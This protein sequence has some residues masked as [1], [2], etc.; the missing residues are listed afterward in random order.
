MICKFRHILFG[1]PMDLPTANAKTQSTPTRKY[2]EIHKTR[3]TASIKIARFS[4]I[5]KSTKFAKNVEFRRLAKFPKIPYFRKFPI[6]DF[7]IP[8]FQIVEHLTKAD[9]SQYSVNRNISKKCNVMEMPMKSANTQKSN[10]PIFGIFKK[11]F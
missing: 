8:K 10:F 2:R 7:R 1:L 5:P 4:E 9:I 3:P 11:M 6:S